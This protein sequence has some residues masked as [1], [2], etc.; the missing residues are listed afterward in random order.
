MTID[1]REVRRFDQV[2]FKGPGILKITQS[3]KESLT[4]HAPSYVMENIQSDVVDGELRL[5]YSFPKIV[6]LKVHR[7]VISYSLAVRDLRKLTVTGI[8]RVV[9]PDLDNDAVKIEL[10]G[11]GQIMLEHLTADKLEVIISGAGAVKARGDVEAQS[12]VISGAG[13]YKA[14]QLISDF[15]HVK[16]SGAGTADVSVSD[17]LD[18]LISGAGSVTY[19]GYPEIVKRITGTGKLSRRRRSKRHSANGE[20]HG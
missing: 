4:I 8:G 1:V 17:D 3:D 14:Q 12:I 13:Q 19:A 16:I 6:S 20:E 15:A 18:V 11:I 5:G 9:V 7:E 10:T 2:R